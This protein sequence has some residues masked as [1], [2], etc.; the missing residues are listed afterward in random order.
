MYSKLLSAAALMGLFTGTCDSVQGLYG[1]TFG[2][3]AFSV[4][5]PD[6]DL[7]LGGKLALLRD[8]HEPPPPSPDP[9]PIGPHDPKNEQLLLRRGSR[10]GA[11]RFS[12]CH[13]IGTFECKRAPM[14]GMTL[15]KLGVGRKQTSGN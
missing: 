11:R 3:S 6:F 10:F 1:P 12:K 2:E 7:G 8:E 14:N 15:I 4:A 9:P 5:A 13:C